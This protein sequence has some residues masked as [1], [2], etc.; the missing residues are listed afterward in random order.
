[1]PRRAGSAS[2]RPRRP[3][4]GCPSSA[5]GYW[6]H[7]LVEQGVTHQAPTKRFGETVLAVQGPRRHAA[8]RWSACPVPRTSRPGAPATFRPSTRSAASTASACCMADA[9][10][11]GAILTDV[12]G[13]AEIGREGSLVRYQASGHGAGRHRRHPRSPAASCR[14]HGRRLGPPH[15]L[16]R[17]GRCRAGA[18]GREAGARPSHPRPPS[19]RTATISARSTSASPAASCSRSRPTIRALPP[20]SR[21]AIARAGAEAAAASWSR[22][23]ARSR[24]RCRRSPD[25]PVAETIMTRA[26]LS[27]VHRFEPGTVPGR[28]PMLLLHGTGGDE[29]DLLPARAGRWHPAPR[30]CRRAARCWRTACRA[31]SAGWRRACSTRP[32]CVRRTDELADFVAEAREAYGLQA[33]VALGFS[34]GANIAAA[35]AAAA[36]GSARRRRPAAGDGAAGGPPTRPTCTGKPVL[37][38]SGAADPIVPAE[39]AARLAAMLSERG[40]RRSGTRPCRSGMGCHRTISLSPGLGCRASQ[41][42]RSLRATDHGQ[43]APEYHPTG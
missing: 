27:F 28:P 12:F 38:L 14:A 1:M 15:R 17:R 43:R 21:V 33:P 29:A 40:R 25:Q 34:N 9:A 36:P 26:T 42:K 35:T 20:T 32:T 22:T 5:I 30:C 37:L 31:S 18:D 41:H 13:F 23:A 3:C 11:T 6:T 19:R 24:R 2:A 16:S 7:R 39:N 4:S 10:P 8:C